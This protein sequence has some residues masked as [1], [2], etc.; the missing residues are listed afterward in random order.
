MIQF[1]SRKHN[2]GVAKIPGSALP[3]SHQGSWRIGIS[4]ASNKTQWSRPPKNLAPDH[5]VFSLVFRRMKGEF[6]IKNAITIDARGTIFFERC[7]G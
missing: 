2:S 7:P 3:L 5:L 4:Q 1:Q 6:V